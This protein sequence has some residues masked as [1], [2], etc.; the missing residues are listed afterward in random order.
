[1]PRRVA[2]CLEQTCNCS[3]F[4]RI[5]PEFATEFSP[6]PAKTIIPCGPHLLPP[7]CPVH[8][9]RHRRRGRPECSRSLIVGRCDDAR[10]LLVGT[11]C[12]HRFL[13]FLAIRTPKP[14][15]SRS[16]LWATACE[17]AFRPAAMKEFIITPASVRSSWICVTASGSC[18]TY[19]AATTSAACRPRPAR[20]G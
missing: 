2:H 5:D 17:S 15:I 14:P 8:A 16:A 7:L 18:R 13:V 3:I 10:S 4:G 6:L 19:R 9:G 12:G 11:S 20:Y 1:M